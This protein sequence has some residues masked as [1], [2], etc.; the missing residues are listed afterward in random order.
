MSDA[1][2]LAATE[3]GSVV[4]AAGCGKTELIAQ[5]VGASTGRQLV[6]TH[7]NAGV[8]A[9]LRRMRRHGIGS[10]RVAVDTIHGWSLRYL[11][12]Y[13]ATSGGIPTTDLSVEWPKVCPAMRDLLD[14]PLTKKVVQTSYSGVFVDEYQDCTHDQHELVSALAEIVPVRVL[15]D[16]LQGV[17]RF[18]RAPPSWVE[19]VEDAFPRVLELTTPWRWRRSG[20]NAALGDWLLE[21]RSTLAEGG[22]LDL[23]DERV[24]HVQTPGWDDWEEALQECCF[25]GDPIEGSVA[26]LLK[27]PQDYQH[28][29]RVTGGYLQCVEPIDARDAANTL[30]ALQEA[31]PEDRANI[32][33]SF[34]RLVSCGSGDL[35][36]AVESCLSETMTESDEDLLPSDVTAAAA[37]FLD[38]SNGDST[39]AAAEL[40]ETTARAPGMKVFRRELLRATVDSLRD[41]RHYSSNL[42]IDRL[43]A[44]R[45]LATRMGRRLS[46]RVAGSNLLLKGMEFDHGIVV[47]SRT[48]NN[49]EMYV[50]VTRGSKSLTVLAPSPRF[51]VQPL[52]AE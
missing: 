32:V 50:A 30:T 7:T 6:L 20:E 49:Y 14:R 23:S 12:S 18:D 10:R 52:V 38:P 24:R 35:L 27:W 43:R 33:M 15:G 2:L 39:E 22:V 11:G 9:L 34:L 45:S 3:R 31:L 46:Q 19:I 40:M 29:A 25:E 37:V 21:A 48:F 41:A 13:P 1:A 5:A 16:P 36:D 28:A 47:M 8:E 26:A 51:R 44:R 42:L 4:A 17:F